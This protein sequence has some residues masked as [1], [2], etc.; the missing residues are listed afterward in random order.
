MSAL[1][2]DK[3][4]EQLLKQSLALLHSR[5]AAINFH[6]L[7]GLLFAIACSPEPIKPSEWFDLLWLDDEPQFD[8]EQEARVFYQQVVAMS[9]HISLMA[10]QRRF[11]PFSAHYSPRWQPQLSMWCEGFLLGHHYLEDV[12]V[13]ALDDLNDDKLY[14]QIDAALSFAYTFAELLEGQQLSLEHEMELSDHQLPAAYQSFWQ[15]LATYASA[16]H[17]W[18]D[19]S[20]DFD[21]EQLFLALEPAP[22]DEACPCGSGKDFAKCCLH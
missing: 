13:I 4:Q 9:E 18:A 11:L 22:L 3:Q 15:T 20:W 17:L 7:Q 10:Q 16:G 6:Q 2:F 1:Q 19:K 5:E 14:E 12:W 21:A 8:T